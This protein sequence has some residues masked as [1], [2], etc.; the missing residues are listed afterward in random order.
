MHVAAHL[1]PALGTASGLLRQIGMEISNMGEVEVGS[2]KRAVRVATDHVFR[3]SKNW[4]R[5]SSA[6]VAISSLSSISLSSIFNLSL[7]WAVVVAVASQ[8]LLR[9]ISK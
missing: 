9:R 3:G 5:L 1:D 4:E 2:A 6:G 8:R 7:S